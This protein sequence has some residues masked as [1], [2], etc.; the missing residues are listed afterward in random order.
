ML[1]KFLF[2]NPYDFVHKLSHKL[3]I[4]LILYPYY[5]LNYKFKV[6]GRENIPKETSFI[7]ASNHFSYSD[8]TLL[9]IATHETIAFIAKKELFDDLKLKD[10]ITYLGAIPID[11]EKP[12]LS[13]IKQ[14]K[15]AIQ[16]NW[17]IGIFIEGTR[18]ESREKITRLQQGVAFFAKIGNNLPVLP[19]GIRG[20]QK[21]GDVLEIHIGE[22]IEFDKEKSLEEMTFIYG[23][24]IAELANL[25]LEL[26]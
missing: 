11:R 14:L 4:F 23:Q 5:Y 13:T 17:S 19:I 2:E 22:I 25:K 1:K 9:S 6:F 21:K 7:V 10:I 8:P 15:K 3:I 24:K 16:N 26:N 12:G 20:G 18:N